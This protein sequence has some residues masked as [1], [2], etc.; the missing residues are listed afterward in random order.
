MLGNNYFVVD[1]VTAGEESELLMFGSSAETVKDLRESHPQPVIGKSN[2][3]IVLVDIL[4]GGNGQAIKTAI[5]PPRRYTSFN[6][7]ALRKAMNQA[8][9]VRL[10]EQNISIEYWLRKQPI[11]FWVQPQSDT[12]NKLPWN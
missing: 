10:A 9:L 6:S 2:K 11:Y 8:Y 12:N 7:L 5:S 4:V 3:L 1:S